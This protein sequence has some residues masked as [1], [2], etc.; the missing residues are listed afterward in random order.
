MVLAEEVLDC[1]PLIDLEKTPDC[2]LVED[3][4]EGAYGE[5]GAEAKEFPECCPKYDCKDDAK[6]TYVGSQEEPGVPTIEG[7]EGVGKKEKDEKE[8]DSKKKE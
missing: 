8:K 7:G 1:G 6:I 3:D 5:E 2:T 4:A